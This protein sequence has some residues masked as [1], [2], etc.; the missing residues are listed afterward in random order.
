M[1]PGTLCHTINV[2][3]PASPSLGP[4]HLTGQRV[5]LEITEGVLMYDCTRMQGAEGIKT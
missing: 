2:P 1:I 4:G 3:K 5:E